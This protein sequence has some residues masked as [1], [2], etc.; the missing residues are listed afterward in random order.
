MIYSIRR[1]YFRRHPKA[2]A[3]YLNRR[4]E[5]ARAAYAVECEIEALEILRRVEDGDEWA[6]AMW[7]DRCT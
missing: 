2:F 4:M 3:R 1:W 6:I 5:Q 7:G